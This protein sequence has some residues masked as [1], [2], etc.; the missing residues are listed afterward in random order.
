MKGVF[1]MQTLEIYKCQNP[2]CEETWDVFD[3]N[4]ISG[5]TNSGSW[6][7]ISNSN[8]CP[9]CDDYEKDWRWVRN[10]KF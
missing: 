7:H 4:L 3:G 9:Q 1:Q 5:Y 10:D 6:E 2:F 8:N